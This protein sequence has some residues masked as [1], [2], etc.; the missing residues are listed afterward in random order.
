M[1]AKYSPPAFPVSE[2]EF[3]NVEYGM[4]LRDYFAARAMAG[5]IS[6]YGLEDIMELA[7][8]AYNVADAMMA[9]REKS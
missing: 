6:K 3:N 2:G 7:A 8:I 5:M 4:T 1:T 9:E